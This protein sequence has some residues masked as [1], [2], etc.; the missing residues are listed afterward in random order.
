MDRA[1][2]EP[3]VTDIPGE[4]A[5]R[6]IE[7]H[8][9]YAA[10]GEHAHE[11][12]WDFTAPAVGPFFTDIDGN[13]FLDFTCHIGAAPLG[14]NNPKIIDSLSEFDFLDPIK[15]AGQD[16]YLAGGGKPTETEFPGP[17]GLMD[18]LTEIAPSDLDTV[19]LSNSGAEAIENAM[20]IAAAN[21]PRASHA[22]T[23]HGAFHGR[24][25]GALSL[26][27][28]GS[29]YSQEYWE[30]PGIR[31][32][33]FCTD[34][35][36]TQSTCACSFFTTDGSQLRNLLEPSGGWVSPTDVAFVILEP[37]Q[38]VG[39]YRF[40]S[41]AFM[42]EVE[43]VCAEHDIHLV[44][45][46]IQSGLGR[47]GEW[48]ASD[49]YSITPDSVACAKALRVGATIAAEPTFPAE[50]NRLG[51][52]WGGGDIMGA[53]TGAVTIDTIHDHHLLA[54]ATT[55]GRAMRERLRDEAPDY[56]VDVRGKGLMNAIELDA[57]DRRT[58]AI[59]AAVE[60]GLLLLGCGSKTIRILPPLDVTAREIEM[61]TNV[62][63]AAINDV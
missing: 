10:P 25:H 1:S 28:A 16:I 61:G 55:K 44:V 5:R 17:A 50:K 6:W 37:I 42:N 2:V 21:Q 20:K 58:A 31:D 32:V 4:S 27:R 51:S 40:P 8:A 11:I 24:T 14:Y 35:Q 48:W 34:R 29:V 26:T 13:I 41:D 23:F 52:T 62:L 59:K 36:C 53:M 45:D 57:A 19:F 46:E 33:P 22:I 47:T 30:V 54:N 43:A 18:R 9:N 3:N 38:G 39:G 49:H 15:I 56:V 7:Y 63:L 60:H 12:V